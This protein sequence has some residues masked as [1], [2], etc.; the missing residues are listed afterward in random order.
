MPRRVDRR[1]QGAAALSVPVS[2]HTRRYPATRYPNV[3]LFRA[4][5][6]RAA[7]CAQYHRAFNGM[8]IQ[9]N[10]VDRPAI[11]WRTDIEVPCAPVSLTD[12]LAAQTTPDVLITDVAKRLGGFKR[13]VRRLI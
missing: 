11:E 1:E 8:Q 6:R 10:D 12:P 13:E 9:G 7:V 2:I 5:R 3:P 4:K